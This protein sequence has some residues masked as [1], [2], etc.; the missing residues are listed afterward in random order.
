MQ[1]SVINLIKVI[2]DTQLSVTTSCK[3]EIIV[4][5]MWIIHMRGFKALTATLKARLRRTCRIIKTSK[6]HS[7]V[8]F[9]LLRYPVMVNKVWITIAITI[10]S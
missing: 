6:L 3:E 9:Q 1:I 5:M 2:S 4:I 7:K 10:K 8:I